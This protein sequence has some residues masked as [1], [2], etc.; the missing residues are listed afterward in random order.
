MYLPFY[1]NA[2]GVVYVFDLTNETSLVNLEAW[3]KRV[4]EQKNSRAIQM[5][6]GNKKDLY[7]LK[8]VSKERIWNMQ[9]AL[10]ADLYAEVSAL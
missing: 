7:N 2:T 5:L 4:N 1:K 6:L 10:G 9:S 3:K 8:E